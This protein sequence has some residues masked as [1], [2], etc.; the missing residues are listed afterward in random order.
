MPALS[1]TLRH[2]SVAA[3]SNIHQQ[4]L[5]RTFTKHRDKF[6]LRDLLFTKLGET[7]MTIIQPWPARDSLGH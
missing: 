7:F 1:K 5:Q 2:F 4:M 3:E 6:I